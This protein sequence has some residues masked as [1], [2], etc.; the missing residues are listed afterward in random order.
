[1]RHVKAPPL[2]E[3][4]KTPSTLQEVSIKDDVIVLYLHALNH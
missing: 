4:Q 3:Y 1:M 2:V